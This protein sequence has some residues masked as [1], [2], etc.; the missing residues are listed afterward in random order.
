MW[1]IIHR[2]IWLVCRLKIDWKFENWKIE[3]GKLF[4]LLR[5]EDLITSETWMSKPPGFK[6][7]AG[8]SPD[9][10]EFSFTTY[11]YKLRF[12]HFEQSKKFWFFIR[13]F[14]LLEI[15]KV[16]I[17]IVFSIVLKTPENSV[18]LWFLAAL[19]HVSLWKY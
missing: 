9:F 15:T 5:N 4:N 3:V 18:S 7:L 16:Q 8:L 2:R 12:C 6:K 13:F 14:A 10:I 17:V 19:L 11:R 1:R